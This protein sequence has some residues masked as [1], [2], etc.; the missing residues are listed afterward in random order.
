MFVLPSFLANHNKQTSISIYPCVFLGYPPNHR[1]YKCYNLSTHKIILSRHVVFDE[2]TFPFAS[3]TATQHNQY[4][5]LND[6][7]HPIHLKQM[8]YQNISPPATPLDSE[9]PLVAQSPPPVT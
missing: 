1:G 7:L 4:D 9:A 2:T 5:F 3:N 8:F 6:G